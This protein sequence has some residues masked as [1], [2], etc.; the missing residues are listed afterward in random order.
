[1]DEV[2]LER[3]V[4]GIRCREVLEGLSAYLD[5][6]LPPSERTR[7]DAHLRA[8]DRCQRFGGMVGAVVAAL[9]RELA[10]PPPLEADVAAR[11]RARLAERG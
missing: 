10:D 2:G 4:A 1:M 9:R 6:E 3:E 7:V 5:G 8:C 11:L